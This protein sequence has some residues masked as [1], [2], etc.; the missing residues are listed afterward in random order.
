M[1][2]RSK[3]VVIAFVTTVQI[4]PLPGKASAGE[5]TTMLAAA[6]HV[7]QWPTEHVSMVEQGYLHP[8]PK[9]GTTPEPIDLFIR[10]GSVLPW[11][12]RFYLYI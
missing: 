7:W 6:K 4:F 5:H 2:L 9:T 1:I 11:P 12:G 8:H 10:F 3:Y